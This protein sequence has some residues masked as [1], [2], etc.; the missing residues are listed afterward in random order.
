MNVSSLLECQLNAKTKRFHYS[1]VIRM[2]P[3][4][5][6]RSAPCHFMHALT[7]PFSQTSSQR[8]FLH[9]I[10]L[11]QVEAKK[12]KQVS[13]YLFL[14]SEQTEISAINT[15]KPTIKKTKMKKTATQ[16]NKMKKLKQDYPNELARS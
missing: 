4:P 1:G 3:S 13:L 16:E 5:S 8:L 2:L 15:V 9:F 10:N 11:A 6:Y 14:F 7:F 12:K